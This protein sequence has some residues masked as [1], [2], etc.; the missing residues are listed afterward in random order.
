MALTL[1]TYSRSS[2]QLQLAF[3]GESQQL[4]FT[5]VHA[6]MS[7]KYITRPLVTRSASPRKKENN[8]L[9][10]SDMQLIYDANSETTPMNTGI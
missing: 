10:L 4:T 8:K 5:R 7:P 1:I 3:T 9:L 2:T 6:N